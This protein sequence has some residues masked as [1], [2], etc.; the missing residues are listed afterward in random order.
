MRNSAFLTVGLLTAMLA[1]C[2][3][4]EPAPVVEQIIIR[5][6][7]A[8]VADAGAAPAALDKVALGEEAFQ[9]CTGC[10]NAEAGGPNMSGPNLH[11][12]VGRKAGAVASYDYSDALAGSDITWNYGTL[13][14]FLANPG[15]YV[16]GTDMV[17]G[18]VRDGE[19]RA[20]IVAYLASTSE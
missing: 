10:H 6:P 13:D 1:A 19:R 5:E 7:G 2:G 17:A 4:A 20:A 18:A 3:S 8:P 9:A 15:G 16:P 11:G 12:V 14:R